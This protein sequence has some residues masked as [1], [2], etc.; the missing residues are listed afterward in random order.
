MKNKMKKIFLTLMIAASLNLGK[1]TLAQ[2]IIIDPGHGGDDHGA[3]TSTM[4]GNKEK[5]I[6]EKDLTLEIARKIRSQLAKKYPTF[7]T[8]SLD[9]HVS[10]E[11]R[12]KMADKVQ[13]DLFISI[14]INAGNGDASKGFET[15]YLDN[16]NDVAVKKVES[17]ENKNSDGTEA[18]INHILTDLVIKN[19]V[20]QSK[21]LS[22]M[23]HKEL[24]QS[25]A[26]SFSMKDRGVKPGLFYVLALSKRPAV[27]LEAG[28]LTNPKELKR[29]LSKE[30]QD[31]YAQSVVT[32]VDQ[33]I[34]KNYP[35]TAVSLF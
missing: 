32:A 4:I 15:Y 25:I 29:L 33:Y 22:H 3:K 27:L 28:F 7:L 5:T 9:R 14:H 1:I 18:V 17:V 8:R 20:P 21:E 16:H 19:T 34:K 6:M 35:K 26:T 11:E 23:I 30:F 2:T 10:L 31:Q 12:A 24:N 13:A